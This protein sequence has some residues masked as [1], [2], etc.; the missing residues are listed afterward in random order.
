MYEYSQKKFTNNPLRCL[1]MVVFGREV[2]GD[3][4][5]FSFNYICDLDGKILA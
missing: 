3:F 4:L 5:F 1:I 2:T